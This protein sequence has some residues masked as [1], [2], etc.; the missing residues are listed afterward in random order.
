MQ[1]RFGAK[2]KVDMCN[3]AF[4]FARAWRSARWSAPLAFLVIFACFSS[5]CSQQQPQQ[6]QSTQQPG[7][8]PGQP[9]QQGQ[10]RR[11]GGQNAQA[12]PVTVDK[13]SSK[14]V[15]IEVT[16]IGNVEAYS[17]VSIRAQV[18]GQLME[19]RFQQ[20][21]FVRKG[22]ILFKID[23]EPYQ[24][25]LEQAQAALARDK[26]TAVNARIQA[27]RYKRLLAEGIVPA[28]Q[29]ESFASVADA[30]EAIVK[31][32]EATVKS[33]QLNL[34]YCTI[35]A[36]I[37][38]RTGS[39]MVQPGNLVKANDV[40]M[41]VINQVNPIYVNFTVPQSYLPAIKKNMGTGKLAVRV[42]VP[43]DLGP[44]EQGVL[45]F[46]DNSVDATTGTIRLRG[47]FQNERDR[48]WPGLFVSAVLR[49]SEQ[50]NTTVVPAAAITNGPDGQIVYVVK[51]DR[52]VEA[53]SVVT[54]RTIEGSA[55]IDKG[56]QVG[57]TIVIDGQLRLVPGSRVDIKNNLTG[58][59]P[60][61]AS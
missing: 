60:G 14:T 41:V 53:R 56:L 43:D 24:T 32:D 4:S 50:P 30:S 61:P 37:D 23:E 52:S 20:G 10:G 29:V 42:K 47:T 12:V 34:R 7:K 45:V 11:P 39:L 9:Q 51:S 49:L 44:A 21:D 36:P 33:A 48:L 6:E 55:V 19:A 40:A 17:T 13:V 46:V 3:V 15:P 38:G 26:A 57:E 28:Q 22:Q 2:V 25:E 18:S 59:V 54:T 35:T 16:A 5:G 58:A 8:Q 27:E 1:I 31:S